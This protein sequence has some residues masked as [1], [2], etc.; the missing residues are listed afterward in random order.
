MVLRPMLGR[1]PFADFGAFVRNVLAGDQVATTR[2]DFVGF[3]FVGI[4]Q[5]QDEFFATETGDEVTWS[6]GGQG[7]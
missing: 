3:G 1:Q 7:K 2:G 5:D 6:P 4:G